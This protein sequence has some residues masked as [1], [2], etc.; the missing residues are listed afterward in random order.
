VYCVYTNTRDITARL[1]DILTRNGIRAE[2][3]RSQVKPELREE[4]LR[5]KVDQ[6]IQVI[7]GNPILVQ[8]GLDL[9]DFP[10]IIFYQTGYSI[11]TLRQASRRSWRIGQD[12]PVR[13]HYLHYQGTMQ[14]R[15]LELVGKKLSASLAIEGKL[16]ADGLASLSSGEDMTLML[17]RA[18]IEG[19]QIDGAESVWR[20]MNQKQVEP[21]SFPPQAENVFYVQH[22]SPSLEMLEERS[23]S[24]LGEEFG[25]PASA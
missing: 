15:A 4:W 1:K 19:A 12:K 18:L 7:I 14:E 16:S 10:T 5:D 9:L 11:F 8:T 3:L 20:S 2:I 22:R 23:W 17:A 21:T 25:M 13:I 24:L 6:D